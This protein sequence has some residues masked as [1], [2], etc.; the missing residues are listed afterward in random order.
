MAISPRDELDAVENAVD[1]LIHHLSESLI[2][3][4]ILRLPQVSRHAE[5]ALLELGRSGA[6]MLGGRPPA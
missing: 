1:L 3:A 2:L 6:R 4:A 5:I